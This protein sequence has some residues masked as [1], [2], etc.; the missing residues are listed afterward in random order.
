M[1]KHRLKECAMAKH[2]LKDNK[3]SCQDNIL[4]RFKTKTRGTQRDKIG[5]YFYLKE[6]FKFIRGV[7]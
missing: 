4:T 2:Q 6:G 7:L 1:A 5:L 3:K